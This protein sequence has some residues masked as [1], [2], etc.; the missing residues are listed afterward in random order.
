[1]SS[2]TP[3]WSAGAH[4]AKSL[5]A[6]GW[7]SFRVP[8][9]AVGVSVGLSLGDSSED[10]N[11]PTHGLLFGSGLFRVNESGTRR[12]SAAAYDD[13]LVF[14]IVRHGHAV[15]YC[16]GA[17]GTAHRHEG[18]PF[19]LPGAVVYQSSVSSTGPVFLDA[20]LLV[21]G[22]KVLGAELV[23][24]NGGAELAFPPLAVRAGQG[25][26]SEVMA[27]S[28]PMTVQAHNGIG[29]SL[30]FMA[31][32]ASASQG[33][34]AGVTA[35]FEP[36]VVQARHDATDLRGAYLQMYPLLMEA[37]GAGMTAARADVALAAY[38]AASQEGRADAAVVF[39][40]PTSF[41]IGTGSVSSYPHI[42]ARLP[43]FSGAPDGSI[44]ETATVWCDIEGDYYV[45][46]TD[47]ITAGGD[48]VPTRTSSAVL[49][50]D[51][52]LSES[53]WLGGVMDVEGSAAVS[54]EP[55]LPDTADAVEDLLLVSMEV[56]ASSQTFALIDDWMVASDAAAPFSVID[57]TVELVASELL[58]LGGAADMADDLVASADV[59]MGSDVLLAD[60]VLD[61]MVAWVEIDA[62]SE[63]VALLESGMAAGEQLFMKQPGLVAWV[64]NTDTGA[65]SWY[66]NW[67][68]TSMAVVGD[69]VFA[70]GPDGLH[71]LG[72]DLDG[73]DPIDARVDFGYT[74]FGGYD[75]A[76][77]PKPSEFKK[78]VS[79]LWFG[80]H[81][82][83]ELAA[84]VETYGQGYGPYTYA[85]AARAADQPRNNR[86]VPGKGLNAR[87][88][89]ISLANKAGCAF[90]VHSIAAEVAQST[91]R[92]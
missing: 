6:D 84:T 29:A 82:G 19:A 53:L 30:A 81:A 4:S 1:M 50:G 16:L 41:S 37:S 34:R 14:S 38:V 7:F 75:N 51:A 22:D 69:K 67:A 66:D 12:T 49:S 87:Y 36:M 39:E 88:W 85:M 73:A 3:P 64:M 54:G 74:E 43:A 26:A 83:G 80:Y 46:V 11:E 27:V 8:V 42:S 33:D 71:V 86:I 77:M 32:L 45:L 52:V 47:T 57:T 44:E 61:G 17:V 76:A 10:P 59:A 91:R 18:V 15:Y 35:V 21:A 40:A 92:L 72:G 2:I 70:A 28:A 68:F 55:E 24:V 65:V 58:S 89:R 79:G 25:A 78:R 20:A 90:E 31:P 13:A 63:S 23:A 62:Q 5:I 48:F 60:S 56:L 9:G